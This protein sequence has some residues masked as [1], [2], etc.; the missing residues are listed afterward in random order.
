MIPPARTGRAR[1]SSK[2]VIITDHINR[3]DLSR[4]V[5]ISL[6]LRAVLMKLILPRMEET[7]AVCRDI[8]HI[9]TD[10]PE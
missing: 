7:P 4:E 9:S 5:G 3:G 2:A 10:T 1:I 8:I 6:I